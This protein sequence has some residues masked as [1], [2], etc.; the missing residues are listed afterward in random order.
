MCLY[1]LTLAAFSTRSTV[2]RLFHTKMQDDI[3]SSIVIDM[4]SAPDIA[5]TERELLLRRGGII[6]L[7]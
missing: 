2:P 5:N 1:Y 7:K 4:L 6:R 3:I